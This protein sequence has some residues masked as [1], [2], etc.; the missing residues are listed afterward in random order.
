MSKDSKRKRLIAISI[1]L[2]IL[3]ISIVGDLFVTKVENTSLLIEKDFMNRFTGGFIEDSVIIPGDPN[4]RIMILNVP[5]VI[6]DVGNMPSL[7][8][9]QYN[10]QRT[11]QALEEAKTDTTIKGVLFAVDSPGGTVYHSEELHAKILELKG[12][13]PEIL[14]YSSMGTV[15][16]SGG[17]YISAPADK[18]FAANETTTGSIGV[19]INLANYQ[20]LEEKLG[21]KREAFTSGPF[22][23]MGS[24]SRE[25]TE[26][27]RAIFQ[28]NIDE[29]FERFFEVVKEGRGYDEATLREIADG[30][31]YTGKQAL[32]NGLIDEIGYQEDAIEDLKAELDL[33]NPEIFEKTGGGDY[34]SLLNMKVKSYDFFGKD[35]Q[36]E[37]I[38]YLETENKSI[39]QPMYLLGGY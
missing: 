12:E 8:G 2:A 5:G 14:I 25:M 22:K 1:A 24:G 10:H 7:G 37:L 20:D 29:S 13:R 23:D 6:V 18:I 3:L 30:R 38:E 36:L 4:E 16:A 35:P 28:Q 17:Y 21:I 39:P 19:I 26:E 15:A 9:L 11:L 33:E 27:E 34:F 32:K 31:T